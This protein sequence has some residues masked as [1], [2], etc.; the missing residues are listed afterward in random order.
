MPASPFDVIYGALGK[1]PT[2]RRVFETAYGVDYA[3]DAEPFGYVTAGEL[4]R[5]RDAIGVGAGDS[6]V[7]LGCGR[8]GPGLAVVAPT[9][10]S[11]VGVDL[12]SVAIG[13]ARRRAEALGVSER[14][15]Y[16]VADLRDTGL[17]AGAYA[18]VLSFDAF[19]IVPEPRRTLA[20]V[21]RLLVPG[22]W[23]AFTTWEANPQVPVPEAIEARIVRD[24]RPLLESA[25]FVV[26]LIEEPAGWLERQLAVYRGIV[27]ERAALVHELGEAP[28]SMILEEAVGEPE[29]LALGRARRVFVLARRAAA[30]S[31]PRGAG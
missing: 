26:E 11:L 4:R 13:E 24:Y 20:E 19:Q 2:L 18:A 17:P 23:L 3:S 28:A 25:G 30:S 27:A 16:V 5:V 21:S 10:A 6:V 14:V 8:G 15:R 31:T 1:S 22:G 7:D 29:R 12:S 9:G